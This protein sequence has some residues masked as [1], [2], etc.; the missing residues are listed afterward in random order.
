MLRLLRR[1]SVLSTRLRDHDL[2]VGG[3][4]NLG[5]QFGDRQLLSGPGVTTVEW[6]SLGIA[7]VGIAAA[8]YIPLKIEAMK[9]PQLRIE[10][11]ADANNSGMYGGPTRIVHVK[12]VNPP[13][14]GWPGKWLLRNT[15]TGATVKLTY[16]SR[17]D[18]KKFEAPG[19]WSAKPEPL[20]FL[21]FKNEDGS[22]GIYQFADPALLPDTL[23]YDVSPGR[24]G[25]V[26]AVALKRDG[27]HQAYAFSWM[28]YSALPDKP[29]SHSSLELLH[30][31]YEITVDVEAGGIEQSA[32]FLLHNDGEKHTDL[33][34][35]REPI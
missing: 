18:E 21:P 14:G 28:L 24:R 33:N 15:A 13:I 4:R 9:R 35:D 12:I 8:I 23:V 6:I 32:T 1:R 17:S 5:L 31:A 20:Q 26:V 29:L 34:L 16:R 27:E 3:T 22:E 7:L 2:H 30:D 25:G 19:K 11:A 10:W